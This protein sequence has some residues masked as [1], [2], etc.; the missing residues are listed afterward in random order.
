MQERGVVRLP[1][2]APL[3]TPS[4]AQ[5]RT[6]RPV[7]LAALVLIALVL[8]LPLLGRVG[9]FSHEDA[10]P[11]FRVL[12]Y[13]GEIRDG[14]W[15]PQTFPR[16]FRG[17][18][19]AFPR[20]YPP[21][22]NAVAVAV[23]MAT[24]DV[25]AG[26]H[27]SF[28]VSVIGSALAMYALLMAWTGSRGA[29][30]V[31]ALAYI[32]VP[33]RFED[34]FIRGA[35]AESWAFVWYP[36]ILLGLWRTGRE[37]RVPAYLP[38]VGA[39]LVLTHPP[40]ALY[41]AGVVA[42][43]APVWL[44]GLERRSG[45]ALG[46]A[47]LAGIGLSAWFWL[48]QQYY[49]PTVWASMPS[50][51]WSDI[52]FAHANRV[53]LETALVGLPKR[54]GLNLSVGWL[55][56]VA[57][58]LALRAWIRPSAEPARRA[59]ERLARVTLVPWWPLFLFLMRPGIFLSV[60]PAQF[61]YIQFPWRVL[62]LMGLLVAVSFACSFAAARERWVRVACT[63]AGVVVIVRAG[64]SPSVIPAWTAGY[65][66]QQ[67]AQGRKFGLTGR[68]EYLP[69]TV[70]GP[71]ED[72]AGALQ[73]LLNAVSA[74]PRASPGVRI[75]SLERRGSA[76]DVVVDAGA[77]GALVLPTVYY[78][79]YSARLQGGTRLATRDSLGLLAVDVPAGRHAIAVRERLTPVV[80]I[81][82]AISLATLLSVGGWTWWR[83]R[84]RTGAD[85]SAGWAHSS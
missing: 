23:T 39:A 79:F 61:G 50:A 24:G 32:G 7:D 82:L 22:A 40:M 74:A 29:A 67:M 64:V 1:R 73:A 33:Y 81:G 62:G 41:F 17:A 35:L 36:L 52:S 31:G 19:Y 12:E 72:Y 18:G 42:L 47:G 69:R 28:L 11:Y 59:L 65:L 26:V 70:P 21:L 55:A 13:V 63:I 45:L 66:E 30:L 83:R 71:G 75:E 34:V 80:W 4:S 84:G 6:A 14:H 58:L 15:L 57:H 68:S 76:T 46:A 3:T 37:G 25:V 44:P 49:L 38:F 2:P 77:P 5:P 20:F 10:T 16:L 51:V 60:L 56:L 53:P 27:L 9:F 78:D 43:L 48:P 54:N 8:Y 85:S